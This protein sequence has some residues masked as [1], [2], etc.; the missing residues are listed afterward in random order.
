M[1][2]ILASASPRRQE[3]IC[4]LTEDFYIRP[5]VIDES[6]HKYQTPAEYV[7]MIAQRKAQS[8]SGSCMDPVLGADTVV[9]LG[10]GILGKP[11]DPEDNRAMLTALSGRWHAVLTAI[12]LCREGKVLARDIVTTRVRFLQLT[13]GQIDG[14]VQSR[15]GLDKAGGYGIQA[16]AGKYVAGIDGCY[17]NVVG[18]PVAAVAALLK[19]HI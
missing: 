5:A 15:D 17:Y 3:L 7:Q 19:G 16:E 10:A 11:R 6:P 4:L 2:L 14:L 1:S 13:E 9:S 18:L 8:V 12:V